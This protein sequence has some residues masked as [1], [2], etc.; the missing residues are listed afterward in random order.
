MTYLHDATQNLSQF[1]TG[2]L[3]CFP[4]IPMKDDAALKTLIKL[5]E[6]EADCE[7]MQ[8]R[9]ATG[10]HDWASPLLSSDPHKG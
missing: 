2:H 8:H 1:M 6:C 4:E 3:L 5:S 10:H 9:P 7:V